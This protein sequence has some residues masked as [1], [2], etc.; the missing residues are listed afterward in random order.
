MLFISELRKSFKDHGNR[1]DFDSALPKARKLL[2]ED[3][4]YILAEISPGEP[5]FALDSSQIDGDVLAVSDDETERALTQKSTTKQRK[6]AA[7]HYILVG[8]GSPQ[9][10]IT[11]CLRTDGEDLRER[12][13]SAAAKMTMLTLALLYIFME[14]KR[15]LRNV[16][17][18]PLVLLK[19]P[20]IAYDLKVP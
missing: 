13:A 17:V 6:G 19:I 11:N 16:R 15:R 3:F 7:V 10:S 9:F 4:G 20:E 5:I 8:T 14:G 18:L 1:D 12:D 2:L